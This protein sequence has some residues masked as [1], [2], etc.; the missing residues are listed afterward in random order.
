Q[1][2]VAKAALQANTPTVQTQPPAK[3]NQPVTPIQTAEQV[4]PVQTTQSIASDKAQLPQPPVQSIP[5]QN[6]WTMIAALVSVAAAVAVGGSLLTIKL[7]HKVT[8]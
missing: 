8:N 7:T 6:S 5:T 4:T 3:T 2:G 1:Q